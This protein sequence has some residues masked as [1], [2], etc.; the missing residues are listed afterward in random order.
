MKKDKQTKKETTKKDIQYSMG[1]NK[2]VRMNN[3][4]KIALLDSESKAMYIKA[5]D[6]FKGQVYDFGKDKG[7]YEVKVT[8]KGSTKQYN[9]LY[10]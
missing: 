5:K 3:D 4:E 8:I 10:K 9:K 2:V 1:D 6:F 7:V